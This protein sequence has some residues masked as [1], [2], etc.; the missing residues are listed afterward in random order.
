MPEGEKKELVINTGPII[1]LVAA[2]GDLGI[3]QNLYSRV[4]VPQKVCE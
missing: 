1:A 4:V 2:M 3:L